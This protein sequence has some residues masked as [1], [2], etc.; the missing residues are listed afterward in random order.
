MVDIKMPGA[1][2]LGRRMEAFGGVG[3]ACAGFRWRTI[4]ID[5][6]GLANA[7]GKVKGENWEGE[8]RGRENRL[9][10]CFVCSVVRCR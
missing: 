8:D 6:L 2:P 4:T 9:L 3:P 5:A 1:D 7:T 10:W